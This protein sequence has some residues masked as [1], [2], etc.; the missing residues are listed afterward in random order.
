MNSL[1]LLKVYYFKRLPPPLWGQCSLSHSFS[2]LSVGSLF[3]ASLLTACYI[4]MTTFFR[5]DPGIHTHC[6]DK[7]ATQTLHRSV[8]GNDCPRRGAKPG[9]QYSLIP[10]SMAANNNSMI[11]SLC[12]PQPRSQDHLTHAVSASPIILCVHKA[13][14]QWPLTL[15]P[16]VDDMLAAVCLETIKHD[17]FKGALKAWHVSM[18]FGD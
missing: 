16:P 12:S 11:A 5:R 4:R 1:W 15:S 3:I 8:S 6:D 13:S 17:I 10:A 9:W 18:K 2:D 14:D 7:Q